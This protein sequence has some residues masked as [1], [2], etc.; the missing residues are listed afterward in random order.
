MI[1]ILSLFVLAYFY[2]K[3]FQPLPEGT[4]NCGLAGYS[5]DGATPHELVTLMLYAETRGKDSVGVFAN[6][7]ILKA[8][9]GVRGFITNNTE[10]FV[11]LT[12]GA[13]LVMLHTRAATM[14][15]VTAENAHPY[16]F[17]PAT[18]NEDT[19]FQGIVVGTHNGWLFP[20]YLQDMADEHGIA[21]PNVDS[22]LIYEIM[23]ANE[24]DFSSLT[25][26]EGT[27][28]LAFEMDG[29]LHLYR[30]TSKPLY[31]GAKRDG[32]FYSSVSDALKAI[33]CTNIQ[34]VTQN[35]MYRFKGGQLLSTEYVGDAKYVKDLSEDVSPVAWRAEAGY[36]AHKHIP[37]E[38]KT[39]RL[40]MEHRKN[41]IY[42]GWNS[43]DN[44]SP[45][46]TPSKAKTVVAPVEGSSAFTKKK[47]PLFVD[48]Q[49]SSEFEVVGLNKKDTTFKIWDAEAK[50]TFV[51][52]KAINN[53]TMQPI[54]NQAF[55]SDHAMGH[56]ITNTLGFAVLHFGTYTGITRIYT[57][58]PTTEKVMYSAAITIK[59]G[60]VLEVS[61]HIPFRLPKKEEE[62]NEG[63]AKRLGFSLPSGR[64]SEVEAED[65]EYTDVE[66][67][68]V[69][70]S[71][72]G[73]PLENGSEDKKAG[74][75]DD[76]KTVCGYEGK[77]GK[78][79]T[80]S[81][82]PLSLPDDGAMDEDRVTVQRE[83]L[84]DL[85]GVSLT[86]PENALSRLESANG[87]LCKV[88]ESIEFMRMEMDIGG[89]LSQDERIE[90]AAELV[91]AETEEFDL[92]EEIDEI[93]DTYK[94]ANWE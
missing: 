57:G 80:I 89:T 11:K 75:D 52:I 16:R 6:G 25:T 90:I 14:G 7:K 70:I 67:T 22:K 73:T 81:V 18:R 83:N 21:L 28:A 30:R 94:K 40:A 93:V 46:D 35:L 49:L 20:T 77:K 51:I 36:D 41:T 47:S 45:I 44:R 79:T 92:N 42:N 91:L 82:E 69:P 38:S 72:V 12:K 23:I 65:V 33:D 58:D 48:G 19:K 17:L 68:T 87:K 62:S 53:K 29:I 74:C 2:T 59:K 1:L 78:G 66:K 39:A 26:I 43:A 32:I 50:E 63:Y 71:G 37:H 5:G 86:T 31:F 55:V 34:Q 27:M 10:Q 9:G 4:L 56:A 61:L 15:A 8:A 84:C 60:R 54:K 85:Y 76:G 13:E 88:Q 3:Y 64:K 24:M